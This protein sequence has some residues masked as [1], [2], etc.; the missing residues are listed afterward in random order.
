METTSLPEQGKVL[1]AL[2]GSPHPGHG[3][4]M[5]YFHLPRPDS[6]IGLRA[7]AQTHAE[8]DRLGRLLI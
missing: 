7:L 6:H 5:A 3:F 8:R 1:L 2:D 4:R